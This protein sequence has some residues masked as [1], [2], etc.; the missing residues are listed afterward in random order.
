MFLTLLLFIRTSLILL[1]PDLN[2]CALNTDTC[3]DNAICT[4][5]DGSFDCACRL[6]FIGDGDTCSG[7]WVWTA[8]MMEICRQLIILARELTHEKYPIAKRSEKLFIIRSHEV[9]VH[10]LLHLFQHV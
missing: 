1:P 2:E 7:E 3:D 5:N 4:D 6:G 9:K 8:C 10:L